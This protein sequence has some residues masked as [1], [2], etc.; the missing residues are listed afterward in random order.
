M[1]YIAPHYYGKKSC[2]DFVSSE[3]RCLKTI[4]VASTLGKS[5]SL[6]VFVDDGVLTLTFRLSKKSVTFKYMNI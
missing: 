3:I 1:V 4:L 5:S 6:C 2:L